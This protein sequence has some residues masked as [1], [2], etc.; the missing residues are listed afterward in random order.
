[1]PLIRAIAVAPA[2]TEVCPVAAP[3]SPRYGRSDFA[4]T[5]VVAGSTRFE[6]TRYPGAGQAPVG[7]ANSVQFALSEEPQTVIDS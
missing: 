6:P 7:F 1:M 2:V 5:E 3:K 4:R